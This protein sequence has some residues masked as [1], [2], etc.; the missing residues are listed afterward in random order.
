MN[1]LI[2][3]D[4]GKVVEKFNQM[5]GIERPKSAGAAASPSTVTGSATPNTAIEDLKTN[6]RAGAES[7]GVAA[8]A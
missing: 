4:S 3:G 1:Y 8:A 6:K 2:D 5:G 7:A